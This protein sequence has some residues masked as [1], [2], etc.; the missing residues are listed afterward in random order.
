MELITRNLGK[1]YGSTWAVRDVSLHVPCGAVVGFLGPN[2]AGKT[3]I[4]RMLCGLLQPTTGTIELRAANLR[5]P[6]LGVVLDEPAFTPWLTARQNVRHLAAMAGMDEACVDVAL[7]RADLLE[8]ADKPAGTF[9]TGM[10]KR[11]AIAWAVVGSPDLLLLDEPFEGL[12]PASRVHLRTIVRAEAEQGRTI[13]LSSH[14]LSEIEGL[15]NRLAFIYGGRLV[16]QGPMDSLLSGVAAQQM[17]DFDVTSTEAAVPVLRQ[18]SDDVTTNGTVA[19]TRLGRE[20]IPAAVSKLVSAGVGVYGVTAK[21]LGLE[22]LYLDVTGGDALPSP[23]L[24]PPP[25]AAPPVAVPTPR[26]TGAAIRFEVRKLFGRRRTWILALLPS[27]LCLLL[28]PLLALVPFFVH[29]FRMKFIIP[30]ITGSYVL[31]LSFARYVYPLLVAIATAGAFADEAGDGTLATTLLT[32]IG[33]HRLYAAKSLAVLA[34]VTASLAPL[35]LLY[36]VDVLLAWLVMDA[37][38]WRAYNHP[39][40]AVMTSFGAIL[41]VYALAHGALVGYWCLFAARGRS[42]GPTLVLGLLPFVTFAVVGV[43][44][45]EIIPLLGL[46]ADPT[47]ALFTS[48]YAAIGDFD[49]LHGC[50]NHGMLHWP[51]FIVRDMVLLV[52]QGAAWWLLGLWLFCSRDLAGGRND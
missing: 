31:T 51:P 43:L 15:C 24:P 30:A 22:A 52:L 25:T 50:F 48:Q 11:L 3:T 19:R 28:T 35:P 37:A 46:H 32:G 18:A 45:T 5:S 47:P 2:G 20:D 40:G 10:L 27:T 21:R 34:Y 49:L 36:V 1:R 8:A 7:G 12:D 26:T 41:C 13:L 39:M 16:C 17:V 9:S 44:A 38:W 33:R 23:P 14:L 29:G 42:T 6:R 4:I